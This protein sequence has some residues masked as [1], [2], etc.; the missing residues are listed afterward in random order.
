MIVVM[1]ALVL[2]LGLEAA[3]VEKVVAL[4]EQDEPVVASPNQKRA[5]GVGQADE[6]Q[7]QPYHDDGSATGVWPLR[8]FV[9]HNYGRLVVLHVEEKTEDGVCRGPRRE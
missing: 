7:G 1:V 3:P 9:R 2:R 4:S 6:E 8:D 5:Y